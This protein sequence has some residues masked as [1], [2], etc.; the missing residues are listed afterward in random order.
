MGEIAGV[1]A[2]YT[3]IELAH[4][5]GCWITGADGT[6]FL[7]FT[8]GIAVASTGHCHPRVVAAICEQAQRAVHAQVNCY[9]HPLLA[10]LADALDDV[11]PAPIDTFFCSNSGAEAVEAAVKLA[12]R[13]TGRTNLI[14]FDGAFHGRTA[15]TM[16]MGSSRVVT[17]SGSQPLPAGITVAPYPQDDTE[18][19]AARCLAALERILMT[20]TAP[21]ETAAVFVEPVLGEG[22]YVVPSPSFVRGLR[23]FCDRH[24]LVLVADEVQSGFGRT[25]RFFAFEHA[26]VTPDIV[27]MAKGL[28]SGFPMSAIGASAALMEHWP[29]GTHGGTYG[30]NPMG[31]AAALATLDVIRSERLVENARERGRQLLDGLHHLRSEFPAIREVRGIGLMAA[32]DVHDEHNVDHARARVR[33]IIEHCREQSRLLVLPVGPWETSIRLMPPLVVDGA[34][35]SHALE[36]LRE[37]LQ[38]AAPADDAESAVV[39]DGN[40]R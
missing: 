10:E 38:S 13:A 3:D 5:S 21:E 2:R 9:R 36:A 25:G 7:D 34:E 33:A 39:A 17:R 15:L 22:G 32:I 24:A 28:A 18:V 30:G 29:P 26:G 4:A 27:V 8:S 1:W 6:R 20:H 23:A 19:E 14:V 12:R 31:C 11:T 40:A 35:I 37:A 16:A